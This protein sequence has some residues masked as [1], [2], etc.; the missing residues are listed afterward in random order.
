M[1]LRIKETHVSFLNIDTLLT[2]IDCPLKLCVR[3]C[4]NESVLRFYIGPSFCFMKSRKNNMINNINIPFFCHKIQ[5]R[6]RITILSHKSQHNVLD[7]CF[8]YLLC[9]FYQY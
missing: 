7:T 3:I 4:C 6:P 5:T 9:T 8:K 2:I 1:K